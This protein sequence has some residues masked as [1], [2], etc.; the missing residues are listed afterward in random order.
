[1]IL[2]AKPGKDLSLPS[3]YWPISLIP[4]LSKL[5]EIVLQIVL[6]KSFLDSEN[7]IPNHQ[8]GFTEKCGK[9]EEVDRVTG[10]IR[11]CFQQKKIALQSS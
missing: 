3:S 9:V 7:P 6:Y 1:M 10:E 4:C 8:F 11:K 5:F 2:I